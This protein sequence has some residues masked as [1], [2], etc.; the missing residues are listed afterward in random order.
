MGGN[1]AVW[2]R[3]V[4]K[5]GVS[6]PGLFGSSVIKVGVSATGLFGSSVIKVGVFAPDESRV[7]SR[8][9]S[10]LEYHDRYAI[11]SRPRL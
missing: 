2:L 9:R 11:V 4:V 6:A 8:T 1:W 10:V 3:C 7:S 5:V